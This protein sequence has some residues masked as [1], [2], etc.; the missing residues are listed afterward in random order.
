M[1]HTEWLEGVT[2]GDSPRKIESRTGVP[3]RTVTSQKNRGTISA[4]NVIKIAIGYGAHPVGAL[5]E[6]GYLDARYA[7]TIDPKMAARLLSEGEVADEVLRRMKL[8]VKSDVLT[9][10][11]NVVADERSNARRLHVTPV[12]DDEDDGIPF[13][14]VADSS[15]EEGDGDPG[16]YEP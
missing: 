5:V 15:P 4:E 12:G 9:T 14:A 11:I 2:G 6:T 16:S 13:D 7:E 10:D 1:T 3:F 8:G